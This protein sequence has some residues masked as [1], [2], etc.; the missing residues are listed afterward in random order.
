M[1]GVVFLGRYEPVRLLGEGGMGRVYIARDLHGGKPVVVKVM[2]AHI[3]ADP[4]FRD[5]FARETALMARLHHPNAVAFLGAGEDA[6]VGPFLVMEYVQGAPLDKVL[7]RTERFSPPRLLRLIQQ[8]CGVLQ[9]AHNERI[10][11]CDL[12][13]ANLMVVDFDSPSE[14]LKVMDF[15][16]ARL[17]D[18]PAAGDDK[19]A[20]AV[21]TP[22]YM[23]PEQV[24]GD[25]VDH[26]GDLYSVGVILFRLL[27]GRL[28]YAGETTMEILMA[29]AAADPPTFTDLGLA[30]VIPAAVEDLVLA[31]LS[32]DPIHRPQS[33]RELAEYY[34]AA[35]AQE[36]SSPDPP[37]AAAPA[38]PA[39][40]QLP[41]KPPPPLLHAADPDVIVD[42]LEAWMPEQVA[43]YKLMGFADAVGAQVI[44]SNPGLVR[45]LVG[46][47][48]GPAK[49]S[50]LFS[51]MGLN[52]KADPAALGCEI[53]IEL[54]LRRK[55]AERQGLLE[56][57]V[58]LRPA[59]RAVRGHPAYQTRCADIQRTLRS[60]L[61]CQAE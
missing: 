54:R 35:L 60:F 30:D 59:R 8:F 11:H 61:M 56:I 36:Y 34:E 22:G 41:S 20:Y 16:L 32:P 43:V 15:G 49:K 33:A 5:R 53:E 44:E 10:V 31:C 1:Q 14:K 3:A 55:P 9:A 37:A 17:S 27:T 2:H 18:Q 58:V 52:R 42:Q 6:Q 48:A 26:R 39:P 4:K 51:L 38:E 29:Q 28:P 40:V 46:K 24:R 19:P 21:G 7:A 12:K 23:P 13:P 45:L 25:P 47:G 57:L 50:G